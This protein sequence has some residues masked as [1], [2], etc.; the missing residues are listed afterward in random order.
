[1]TGIDLWAPRTGARRKA[2][3]TLPSSRGGMAWLAVLLVIGA[4][5]AFQVGRQVYASWSINQEAARIQA[6]IDAMS[7]Q[8]AA[9]QRELDYLRSDAYISQ[10]AKKLLNLGNPNE[11]VLII[12]PGR[13]APLPAAEAERA[14]APPPLLQQWLSLFF[15][16]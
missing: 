11:R 15:G 10:E 12:P 6:E 2:R 7:A 1:M 5:V 14:K 8:N 13:E 16:S 4:F 9:L 3:Y